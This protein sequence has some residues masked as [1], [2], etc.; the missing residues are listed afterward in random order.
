MQD[1]I[2]RNKQKSVNVILFQNFE[3]A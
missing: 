2:K 1:S 3:L